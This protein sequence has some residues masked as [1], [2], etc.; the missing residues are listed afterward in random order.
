MMCSSPY[1][2]ASSASPRL[3]ACQIG[4]RLRRT[5]RLAHRSAE[6]GDQLWRGTDRC[7]GMCASFRLARAAEAID[8]RARSSRKSCAVTCGTAT[9]STGVLNAQGAH[10][11][12]IGCSKSWRKR[13][14]G[15]SSDRGAFPSSQAKGTCRNPSRS[16]CDR[17]FSRAKVKSIDS[18][19]STGV[20]RSF[21][22]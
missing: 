14:C 20:R 11:G 4:V 15:Q 8:T 21:G 2:T 16:R 22:T 5:S 12:Q 1:F 3:N 13:S 10:R 7:S 9:I 18:A 19:T 6:L 17:V